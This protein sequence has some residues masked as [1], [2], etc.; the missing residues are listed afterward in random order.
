[1]IF[2]AHRLP[3]TGPALVAAVA[4]SAVQSTYSTPG[5]I[6]PRIKGIITIENPKRKMQNH[7]PRP[8]NLK[9]G[10]EVRQDCEDGAAALGF[11]LWFFALIF[12][13]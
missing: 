10:P 6:R 9:P 3:L 12:G 4:I 5:H 7:N 8:K 11:E 13:F 1:V 2:P